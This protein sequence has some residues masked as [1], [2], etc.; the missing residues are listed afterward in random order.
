MSNR[1]AQPNRKHAR[2]MP[3]YAS[4][5]PQ[6]GGPLQ[7]CAAASAVLLAR[8]TCVQSDYLV[9]FV[10]NSSLTS[11]SLLIIIRTNTTVWEMGLDAGVFSQAPGLLLAY[12]RALPA[13]RS[14]IGRLP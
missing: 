14:C 5:L 10:G 7:C 2:L 9:Q 6:A 3:N 12:V 13:S 11:L 1:L 8:L 4:L